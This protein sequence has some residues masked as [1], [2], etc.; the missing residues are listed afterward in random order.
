MKTSISL[1]LLLALV[2]TGISAQQITLT[3]QVS[4]HNSKYNTGKIECVKDA[5]A[6]APFT[7]SDNTD[8][9]GIFRLDFV[10]LRAGT[11]VELS[12]EKAGYEVVN[13]YDLRDVVIGRKTPLKIY[14]TTKGQLAQAQAELYNV[15]L[16]ALTSRYDKLIAQLR[17]QGKESDTLITELQD[18]LNRTINNRFEAEEIMKK[19]LESLK[20]RLPDIALELA[21]INLD[22]ASD[23]YLRAYEFFKAG[24][25]EKT[26]EVLDEEILDAEA[27]EVEEAIEMLDACI[28]QLEDAM[29]SEE[30]RLEIIIQSYL[31]KAHLLIKKNELRGAIQQYEFALDLLSMQKDLNFRELVNVCWRMAAVYQQMGEP[32]MGLVYQRKGIETGEAYRGVNHPDLLPYYRELADY[33]HKIRNLDQ[34]ILYSLKAVEALKSSDAYAE[35]EMHAALTTLSG[36]YEES[37]NLYK[38][39]GN[40]SKAL[41]D[42]QK[43]HDL[44]PDRA[45]IKKT[46]KDLKSKIKKEKS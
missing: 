7:K 4:I 35:G 11:S 8:E 25:I 22:F 34:S 14:I 17:K 10:G 13:K 44:Q 19:Q 20:Q 33:F 41:E 40:Y 30:K 27:K 43:V 6:S 18:K 24:E 26:I 36:R 45:D 28:A 3:G 9:N 12:L 21:S 1:L 5:Y 37:A 38:E 32:V 2:L 46:I 42:Y 16:Q 39:A 29:L 23:M 15:S 31:L